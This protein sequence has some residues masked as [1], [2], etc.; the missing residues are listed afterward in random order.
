M[1]SKI[2]RA[3]WLT[4]EPLLSGTGTSSADPIP[5]PLTVYMADKQPVS[6]SIVRKHGLQPQPYEQVALWPFADAIFRLMEFDN[7]TSTIKARRA[8]IH[9][10]IDTEEMFKSIFD[11]LRQN[12]V[13]P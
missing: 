9:D 7:I 4:S 10:C 3:L 13:I 2:W 6:E 5:T 11:K 8:G 1:A 12:R